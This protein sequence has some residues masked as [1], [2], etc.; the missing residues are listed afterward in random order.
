MFSIRHLSERILC[1]RWYLVSVDFDC[2]LPTPTTADCRNSSAFPVNFY[3]CLLVAQ[4]EPLF[5][6]SNRQHRHLWRP[7]PL[8][9]QSR[10]ASRQPQVW[11]KLPSLAPPGFGTSH[12]TRFPWRRLVLDMPY[13][14]WLCPCSWV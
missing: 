10:S 11:C 9:T 6:R 13:F 14:Y 8:P 3:L 12:K 4:P 2:S 5:H 1:P 7:S